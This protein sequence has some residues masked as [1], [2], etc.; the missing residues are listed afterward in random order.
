MARIRPDD[1]LTL[2]VVAGVSVDARGRAAYS[3]I[4]ADAENDK[5]RGS[6]RVFDP[7][8][9]ETRTYTRGT[10]HDRAP[11]W[12]PD[13][14]RLMFLSDRAGERQVWLI[15]ADGGEPYPA[16]EVPGNVS[17]AEF[18]PDGTRI[19]VIATP[20]EATKDAEKRGW[21]RIARM[22]FRADGAGYF[23]A[24]PQLWVLDLAA[25]SAHALTD[26]SGFVGAPSWSPDGKHICFA[27]EHRPEAD[28]LFK[29]ELWVVDADGTDGPRQICTLPGALETPVWSPDGRRIAVTGHPDPARWSGLANHRLYTLS[30]DGSDLRCWTAQ[31]EWTCANLVIGD[32]EE[33]GGYPAPRWLDEDSMALIV[34]DRGAARVFRV[35]SSGR[36]SELTPPT[37]SV[38]AFAIAPNHGLIC[39]A[40]NSNTPPELYRASAGR[41]ERLTQ[42]TRAWAQAARLRP[43]EQTTADGPAGPIHVWRL[44]RSD[45]APRR[46]EVQHPGL[47]QIHGGPHFAYG[48]TFFFEF[49]LLASAGYDVVYC[50]PRGSQGYGE[51]FASAIVGDWAA[52]AHDDCMAALDAAISSGGIDAQRLGVAGGSYGG[53]LTCWV[54]GHTNRFKAAVAMR[55]ATNLTS[56]W[57]TSE[58]GRFLNAELGGNPN[59]IPDVYRANSPLTYTDAVTTPVLLIHSERDYRCPIEQAEQ[60]FTALQQRGA[61]VELLRFLY[62]DHGLSRAGPPRA[63]VARLEAILDWFNRHLK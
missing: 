14:R 63:R 11:K 35:D 40:S 10:A 52:P 37:H 2:P 38:S 45:D 3:L 20:S 60:F 61:E 44:R 42:E 58:V 56:L 43:A 39:C 33:A 9:K 50:N 29:T 15:D 30:P 27:G 28:T 34:T 17:E 18:S 62:A 57:G 59:E 5:Y 7:D 12:S 24:L 31:A 46:G 19:A 48:N 22:R 41:F 1:F 6:I 13:G 23:D 49:Q 55:S 53:Y 8:S 36:A 25:G 51:P 47:L 21:R 26:G 54:I 16:P 4:T 32:T